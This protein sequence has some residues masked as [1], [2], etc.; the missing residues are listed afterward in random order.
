MNKYCAVKTPTDIQKARTDLFAKLEQLNLFPTQSVCNPTIKNLDN[1]PITKG[2]HSIRIIPTDTIS[3]AI[4]YHQ[5]APQHKIC[6]LNF[7][8]YKTPG[9]I[10][11]HCTK[12]P[13]QEEA[14]CFCSNLYQELVKQEN[15][16]YKKHLA[17]NRGLYA[18]E[19]ILSKDISIVAA[20]PGDFLS[21]DEIFMVDVL[22]CAAPNLSYL[23]K[24]GQ[25]NC[26]EAIAAQK[27]RVNYVMNILCSEQYDA[28]I[29]GAFGC[30]VFHCNPNIISTAF[31]EFLKE[32][33]HQM[34]EVIFAIP[35]ETSSNFIS[36][37]K[38]FKQIL[39]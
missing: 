22:S 39:F 33:R 24:L 37:V 32:H 4:E 34:G 15:I 21:Q 7:A 8:S 12:P 19:S 36:F 18:N 35:D 38:N 29:L 23:T 3:A 20:A 28:I 30:G 11:I 9:G 27:D 14:L 31:A 17:L 1:V 25:K 6:L 2:H 13:A 26:A 5:T 10:F 16:W